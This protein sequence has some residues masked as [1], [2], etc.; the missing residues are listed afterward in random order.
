VEVQA[1]INKLFTTQNQ[2]DSGTR[3]M[4][5]TK[6]KSISWSETDTEQPVCQADLQTF[7]NVQ[8]LTNHPFLF[9]MEGLEEVDSMLTP[10]AGRRTSRRGRGMKPGE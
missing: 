1:R 3:D 2:K 7:Y 4:D 9:L 5:E 8:H 6:N 10:T